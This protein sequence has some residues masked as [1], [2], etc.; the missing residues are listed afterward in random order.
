MRK[1]R[2]GDRTVEI[3]APDISAWRDHTPVVVD[4]VVS[5][6]QTMIAT[7]RR[8]VEAGLASPVCLAVHALFPPETAAALRAAGA[9]GIVTTNTINHP[10][11]A[12]DIVPLLVPAVAD[13]AGALTP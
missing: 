9:S 6:G 4:D 8:L 1:V 10:A 12:I 3:T 13:L 2:R 7:V 11:S 5:S